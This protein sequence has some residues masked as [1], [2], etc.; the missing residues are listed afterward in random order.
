M[1]RLWVIGEPNADGSLARISAEIGTLARGLGEA[2]GREVVGLVV[3]AAPGAAAG[4]LAGYLPRVLTVTD[5]D[6]GGHAWA[7]VAADHAA[8]LLAAEPDAVVLLGA[9]PDGRDVAGALAGL[10]DLGVL[11][12]AIGV[13][14]AD[15]RPTVEMSA[16]GGKL[17]TTSTFSGPGGIVTVRPGAIAAQAAASPGVVEESAASG[18]TRLPR[19][20]V[21]ESVVEAGAAAPIEE[22]RIIVSGG[23]GVGGPDGFRLVEELAAALGG[24]VGATRAAV[25]AGWI[26]YAQQI[27]QTGKIVKPQLYLALGISGAIQHK[28]GMQTAETIVAVNRDPD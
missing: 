15:D 9:G 11:A 10:T 12:N 21:R 13:A 22:A 23:R 14:W 1:S 27:G 24:A 4:E 5:A 18:T 8:A 17:I 26:P 19:V 28:V 25:D 2:S 6:A 3:G 20:A 7:A 16:F